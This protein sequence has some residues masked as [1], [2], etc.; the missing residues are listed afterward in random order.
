[1]PRR[2][3]P[4]I[5]LTASLVLTLLATALLVTTNRARE[6]EAFE[7]AVEAT[8]DRVESRVQ[9]YTAL[10]RGTAGVV[11][12]TEGNLSA[13]QFRTYVARLR[14]AEHYPGIQG[15]GYTRW[16]RDADA[17]AHTRA[18]WAAAGLGSVRPWPDTLA[19]GAE[20][21]ALVYLEPQTPPNRTALG[22]NMHSEPTRRAAMDLARDEGMPALTGRV[23][24]VQE[25]DA[26][27]ESP[28]GEG[29]R[30][31]AGF[32]LYVPVY[33]GEGVPATRALRREALVGFASGPF[34]AD[35]LFLGLFGSE[36]RPRVAF[37]IYDGPPAP[38]HL[39]H[40]SRAAGI[41]PA[42]GTALHAERPL[43]LSGRT[44]TIVF[45][46]T[47]ALAR[48]TASR[49]PLV[50]LVGG[51][52]LS[53]LLFGLARAQIR[54]ALARHE[55]ERELDAFVQAL[56]QLVWRADA[57]GQTVWT[58]DRW[59][60]FTG[61][62]AEGGDGSLAPWTDAVDEAQREAMHDAFA[63]ARLTGSPWEGLVPLNGPGEKGPGETRW[64][65][66]QIV[67][68]L[69][70]DGEVGRWFGVHTD[71]TEQERARAA[72]ARAL[73]EKIARAAAESREQAL[74]TSNGELERS[75]R[76][77]QE[78][79]YVA[80]H[81]LQEPLRKIQTFA[82][83]VQQDAGDRLDEHTMEMLGRIQNAARRMSQ[84]IKGVLAVSRVSQGVTERQA[85]ALDE[86]MREVERDLWVRLQETGGR[87]EAGPL[88]T[89]EVDATQ[90]HQLLL[91]L[92]GN[93]LKF[94]RAGVPPVVRVWAEP[95]QVQ[96]PFGTSEAV[97]LHVA[98]NGIGIEEKHL[99]RIFAPFQRLHRVGA[100]EGT[101]VGLA[102]CRRIV[103]RH[104]G[105]LV[106][107]S[108]VGEG[109]TFVA[110]LPVTAPSAPVA[111]HGN[112]LPE[113]L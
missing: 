41:V 7:N 104:G 11:S 23:T 92:V 63:H 37:R 77:L 79:A 1:M 47:D 64:F 99:T 27:G 102:V 58:N 45:E 32:L 66:S 100:Y 87:I 106:A 34:R 80:S 91:N 33:R 51:L 40:D 88:P 95:S 103:E 65:L 108:R 60:T 46:G 13:A 84:L 17:E 22:F 71:V 57:D 98:D 81:D 112:D 48:S 109:T 16:L 113:T 76:E 35:D 20:R 43:Q 24:L 83:L 55:R 74:R 21:H 56:P 30:T 14:V 6:Q 52:L 9:L 73:R 96:T 44:W 3:L 94:Q 39:L 67:P 68:V 49:L 25:T 2:F 69:R 8:R 111:P 26:Q 86:V 19:A 97:Q 4:W 90:M 36:Q 31:Q 82:D 93:A 61:R 89:V 29:A 5:V 38:E 75:N 18:Q 54:A 50:L 62:G 105:T 42:P 110:T 12:A 101:G 10:L 70:A 85:V 59:R 28:Q 107:T 72:D 15:I 53:A 78:F